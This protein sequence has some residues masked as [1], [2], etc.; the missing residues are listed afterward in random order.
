[1]FP[2]G[3]INLRDAVR[4]DCSFADPKSGKRY[5]LGSQ[6]ATLLV[7][8]QNLLLHETNAVSLGVHMQRGYLC[9]D[10]CGVHA[11][12][13]VRALKANGDKC[14][15]LLSNWPCS[16]HH[17]AIIRHNIMQP[18]PA[19]TCT[20]GIPSMFTWQVRPRG[21]HLWEKHLLVDGRPVPAGIFDFALYF[22]HNVK[23]A[24]AANTGPYFY[25]PKMQSHLEAR[26]W[27]DV[28]LDAQART[29]A[30][31]TQSRALLSQLYAD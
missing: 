7:R 6:L 3:Q 21:W 22:F 19:R 15:L 4:R 31:V 20:P 26:L 23:A 29:Q 28:F 10:E 5:Q 13:S 18:Q 17:A 24:K 30:G 1:M 11:E 25:L 16:V 2:Q 27:N 9:H 8:T 14:N 12:P